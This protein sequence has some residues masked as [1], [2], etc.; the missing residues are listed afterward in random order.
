MRSRF[1]L[2]RRQFARTQC[3][4][5]KKDRRPKHWQAVKTYHTT[6]CDDARAHFVTSAVQTCLESGKVEPDGET[7]PWRP[8]VP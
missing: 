3:T 6:G 4:D 1:E 5:S 2:R 8:L 7:R